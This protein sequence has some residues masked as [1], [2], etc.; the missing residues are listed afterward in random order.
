MVHFFA[1]SH[2]QRLDEHLFKEDFKGKEVPDYQHTV[3]CKF[4]LVLLF[5]NQIIAYINR[6]RYINIL[7]VVHLVE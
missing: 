6:A 1:I 4:L 5:L 3:S 7:Y 2:L